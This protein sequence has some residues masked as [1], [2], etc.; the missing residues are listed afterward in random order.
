MN[1]RIKQLIK[2]GKTNFQIINIILKE[3]KKKR[4]QPIIDKITD[5]RGNRSMK[6]LPICYICNK[7]ISTPKQVLAIGKGLYRHKT[8]KC[9]EVV[10]TKKL[11]IKSNKIID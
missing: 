2:E 11:K 9:L 3:F 7:K 4:S 8:G 5:I 6:D 1:K 10:Y